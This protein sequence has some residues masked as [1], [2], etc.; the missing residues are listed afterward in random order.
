MKQ[1]AQKWERE[2]GVNFLKRI[3]IKPGQ[4]VLDFG[5]S[6]GR[7]SIPAAFV[8]GTSGRVYAVDKER[9]QLNELSQK[10]RR[11]N[12][13][14]LEVIRTSDIVTLG[15]N[16]ESVDVVLFYDVLHYLKTIEREKLYSEAH[17]ILKANGFLSVY[18]KHIIGDSPLGHF[19]NLHLDNVKNEIEN[20]NFRFQEK[21]CD[22]ISHDDTLTRGCV[23]NFIKCYY[24]Y[25]EMRRT[26]KN[27][28]SG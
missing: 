26:Q 24:D 27:D 17:C 16:H 11:L 7:Y 25:D 28:F 21:Y 13:N 9:Q 12:L 20:A 2:G 5:A 4:R 6:V 19:R 22:I 1:A 3:G 15:F 10:A 23:F 14:N 18:P 8:V